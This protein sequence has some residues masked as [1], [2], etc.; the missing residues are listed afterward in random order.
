[1]WELEIPGDAEP[2]GYK[3]L[4]EM[5]NL[6]VFPHYRWSFVSPK[7]GKKEIHSQGTDSSIFLYPPSFRLS[8]DVFEHLEFALKYEGLN[9]QILKKVLLALSD[10]AML[11]YIE[12]KPTG[13]YAR[14]LWYLFEKFHKKTLPLPDIKSATYIPLLDPE[15][16]YVGKATYS[17]RHKIL[18]NLIGNTEFSP[19]VRKTNLLIEF[20]KKKIGE[21]AHKLTTQYDPSILARAMRY[22]YTKET[23]SS[24]E[25]ERER[26]D[27]AKLMKFVALLQ[28]ADAI[29]PLSE[30]TLVELQKSIVD[31]RFASNQYRDFQN[32]IGEE[33][34]MGQMII[35]FIPPRPDNVQELMNQLIQSFENME[36]A[37]INAVITAAVLAFAFVF[38]HPFEDG[39]GRIHR[40]LIH[41][42]LANLKF[43]P[44]GV[45]FPISAVIVRNMKNYDAILESFSKPLMNLIGD[46][47]INDH[48]ELQ[49]LQD[50]YDLYRFIDFTHFAEFLFQCV[51]KTVMTDF[52][53]ELSFLVD[54]DKIKKEI[55]EIVD[56]PDQRID[57]LIKCVRQNNGTLSS[58]KRESHF[59]M[60]TNEE[61]EKMEK[62]IS[63]RSP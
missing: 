35:H 31:P 2:L 24:W 27:Q 21:V 63:H 38:I 57:L 60:L 4:V 44:E 1:M 5:F 6:K 32:Y 41:Y 13:K 61:I 12:T 11:Q 18:E 36:K 10:S 43:T 45:V 53:E 46:Y 20:E 30:R 37:D 26:P 17:S 42:T 40:F 51:E 14:V 59:Q 9:L 3:K 62:V 8:E 56:M 47:K 7:W 50:T 16:Y 34:G 28:K 52:K 29:G 39:N 23:M 19:I 22:M 33:P 25:I 15:D 48:G 49:V 54:Y 55:K 58:K